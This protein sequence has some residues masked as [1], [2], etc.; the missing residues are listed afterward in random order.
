MP[1]DPDVLIVGSW[2]PYV[3][4][5]AILTGLL[6]LGLALR[7][8]L[9]QPR[10]KYSSGT[11]FLHLVVIIVVPIIGPLIYLAS[12]GHKGDARSGKV[13]R[14]ARDHPYREGSARG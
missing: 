12:S 14:A 3:I 6:L 1:G 9:R 13:A 5:V 2:Y 7:R 11:S 10:G 8:W 4:T